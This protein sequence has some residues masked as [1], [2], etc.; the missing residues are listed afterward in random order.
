MA[1]EAS[2]GRYSIILH[3]GAGPRP[4]RDYSETEIHMAQLAA[5]GRA[6]LAGGAAALDV[7]EAMVE[8]LELSGL[9]VAGRGAAPNTDGVVEHDASIMDGPS[10]RAGAVAAV[11]GIKSP[12]SAARQVMERT[13]HVMLAGPGAQS[14]ARQAGLAVIEEEPG[15]YRLAVGVEPDEAAEGSHGTVGAVAWDRNGGLAA[16]TS[17][18]G[19]LGKMPGRVGD[20]PLIGA[21]SWAD[22]LVAVSATGKGEHLMRSV[23]AY[24]V[25][26]R[27]RFAGAGLQQALDETLADLAVLGGDGGLIAVSRTGETAYGFNSHGMKRAIVTDEMAQPVTGVFER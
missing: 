26:A 11:T 2:T 13:R 19:T 16:A 23:A 27:M 14:F 20:T 3:G 7:V 22:D 1:A 21:G 10:R 8:G 17:T 9:Y 6:M 4:G 12:V 5:E 24:Q 18:G 25:A 15:W